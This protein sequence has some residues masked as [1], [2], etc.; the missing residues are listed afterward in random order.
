MPTSI[1]IGF[2]QHPDPPKAIL[3]ACVQIKNQLN[4]IDTDLVILFTSP[5]Y[6][7]PEILGIITRTLRPKRLIGSSTGG[8][9]LSNGVTNRG[10]ALAA[11]NSDDMHFGISAISDIANQDMH[12]TGFEPVFSA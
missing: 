2:S 5:Q 4:T 10:I 3:Q 1:S 7:V 11:I 8:I 9:I 6:V 12:F